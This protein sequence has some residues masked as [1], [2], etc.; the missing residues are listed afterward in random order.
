MPIALGIIV[1]M[2]KS[3]YDIIFDISPGYFDTLAMLLFLM[4]TG[5]W[6]Q[7]QTMQALAFDRDYKSFYPIAVAKLENGYEQPILLADLKKVIEF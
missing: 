2:F 7:Q 4:L 1:I 3:T 6:F 5:K